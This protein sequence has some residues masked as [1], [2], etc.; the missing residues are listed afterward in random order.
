MLYEDIKNVIV[1]KRDG[2]EET[3]NAHKIEQAITKAFE[4][5]NTDLPLLAKEA[6][7][8]ELYSYIDENQIGV[9]DIQDI[10]EKVLIKFNY[11]EQAKAYIL[12]RDHR[13]KLRNSNAYINKLFKELVST[14]SDDMDL[15]RE[16]ANI[17]GNSPMGIMLRM[18]SEANK[19]FSKQYMMKP[20]WAY[21]HDIGAI[22]LHDLDFYNITFNCCQIPAGKLLAHGFNTG[23]GF[24]RPPQSIH[25]AA[26]L[27]CIIIQS[28]QNDMY[29]GQSVPL[30][31]YDLA[32][33][34]VKSFKKHLKE[35]IEYEG[36]DESYKDKALELCDAYYEKQGTLIDEAVLSDIE[37]TLFDYDLENNRLSLSY[38]LLST[39]LNR[40]KEETAQAMEA[41]IHNLNSMHSR[42][43][44]Q[45]P[46]SGLNYG[47][48]TTAE[49]RLIIS[50]I[51]NATEAGLG[52]HETPIF[53][54]QVF[55][56]K[57]GVNTKEGDPNYD[58]FLKACKVSAKRLF[59]N[60]ALLDSS[61]NLPYYQKGKPETEAAYM[62]CANGSA[63]ICVLA[64]NG[65]ER[66]M[67]LK[68]FTSLPDAT[69]YK[70][71]DSMNDRYVKINRVI[72]NPPTSNWS[73]VVF[74]GGRYMEVTNDHYLPVCY[75]DTTIRM[76]VDELESG[77]AV[78][79]STWKPDPRN[80]TIMHTHL[81]WL[82]GMVIRDGSFTGSNITVCVGM[83]E[84]ELADYVVECATALGYK[85]KIFERHRGEKGNYY[86]VRLYKCKTLVN[87][88][89]RLFRGT[90]K[91]ERN[92]P[93]CI[94]NCNE[95]MRFL[96]GMIDADGYAVPNITSSRIELGCVNE[97]LSL[98]TFLLAQ[99]LG[100][101]P[102]IY[103]HKRTGRKDQ[104]VVVMKVTDELIDA[105]K[106]NKKK[107]KL[108]GKG[109][110]TSSHLYEQV[111]SKP[112]HLD[113]TQPSY[114][115]ETETDTFD[116]NGMCSHNC[117][118]RVVS[119]VN[120]DEI[121]PGRGN[122]SFT[123]TNLPFLALEAKGDIDTF[124]SKL[125][126]LCAI[127]FEQLLSRYELISQKHVYNLPFLMGQ[128]VWID[129]DKL[130]PNDTIGSVL[131]H[132]S[133]SLGFC[134]LAE[135]LKV[136]IGKHHGESDEA[137]RLGLSIVEHMRQLCDEQA[138]Q[139]HLNFS[140]FATPAEST[141]GTFLRKARDKFGVIKGVT[142]REYV[143]NS[144]HVPVYYEITAAEKIK[145]EG[146]YHKLCNA[147][148]ISYVEVNGDIS[149]NVEAFKNIILYMKDNDMGYGSINHPVDRCPVCGYVG[150]IN[151]TCPKCGRHD[152]E[153]VPV[154]KL[155]DLGV[156]CNG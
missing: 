35:L 155:K 73:R 14:S 140:L 20:E 43:G 120:G 67:N 111:N 148:H 38:K 76:R 96:A 26:S 101:D 61:F 21:L 79:K 11:A 131:K 13:T 133:M 36:L 134:G 29:G 112:Y 12:Y 108:S 94:Y 4:A 32:P 60:F 68:D 54:V 58:L 87:Q 116:I 98:E 132:G 143:T 7:L 23:H 71:W 34:V 66:V 62:G 75:A 104:Y 90:K 147:G 40:T 9:E 145:K 18:G 152:C 15:M 125:D 127:V 47:T 50:E 156:C 16:N 88:L 137:Q 97:S 154:S 33:Y 30:F 124:F 117:R 93:D 46:F 63:V 92:I 56:L 153:A 1:L 100:L 106:C 118:T 49:Q 2:R 123:T 65:E 121:I 31:E 70:V 80:L 42:A 129:S 27:L 3:F 74:T 149:K 44:A 146:P 144:F 52:N 105:M 83:D 51:L 142:D 139:H 136:L 72:I 45:V 84:K 109:N 17:D 119:N 114:C 103:H 48:G 19:Q 64:P 10:V 99:S 24:I 122:L 5:T 41:I 57:D 53:P 59:P 151:S 78:K 37:R 25:T 39:A 102:K 113:K 126:K 130:K 91:I 81:A 115:L 138:L 135:C 85:A 77:F 28:N 55:K 6:M 69:E 150:I 82:M 22:H 89:T 128:G 110:I 107:A 141:A 95:A 8:Y 86:E